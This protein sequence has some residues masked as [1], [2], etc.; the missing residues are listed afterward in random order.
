ML[1]SIATGTVVETNEM[2]GRMFGYDPEEIVGKRFDELNIWVCEQQRLEFVSQLQTHGRVDNFEARFKQMDGEPIDVLISA[3]TTS[4]N[5]EQMVVSTLRDIS[6]RK[7]AERALEK[8]RRRLADMQK[9]AGLGTWMFDT[10]SLQVIWS[11]EAYRLAGRAP[12][13]GIPSHREYL[14][15]IHPDDRRG[16]IQAIRHAMGSVASFEIRIR[17]Q[18]PSGDYQHLIIRGQP[19]QDETGKTIEVYGVLIPTTEC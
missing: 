1:G 8:S 10:Q 15:R 2:F 19:I 3:R 5:D 18:R 13:E 7:E 17:Q 6:D 11:D 12:H 4:I 16:L 9:L 14:R